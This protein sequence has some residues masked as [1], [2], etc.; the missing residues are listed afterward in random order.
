MPVN[1]AVF[2]VVATSYMAFVDPGCVKFCMLHAQPILAGPWY[3]VSKVKTGAN[4]P[5]VDEVM[6]PALFVELGPNAP[7]DT[8]GANPPIPLTTLPEDPLST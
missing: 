3:P 4:V 5:V 6:A 2:V 1:D 7:R 8:V